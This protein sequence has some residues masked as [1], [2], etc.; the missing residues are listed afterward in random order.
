[1]AY[2]KIPH[3]LAF[4]TRLLTVFIGDAKQRK[5]VITMMAEPRFIE[6]LTGLDQ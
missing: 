5:V 3:H 2:H 4:V 1:M 6:V